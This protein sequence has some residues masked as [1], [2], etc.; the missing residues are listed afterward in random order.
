MTF[1]ILP[2]LVLKTIKELSN[3][4]YMKPVKHQDDTQTADSFRCN[5]HKYIDTYPSNKK[6][7]KRTLELLPTLSILPVILA[8]NRA[9]EKPPPM[10]YTDL[11]IYESPHANYKEDQE[12]VYKCKENKE[13]IVQKMLQ[14]YIKP[15]RRFIICIFG[16]V[17]EW[18]NYGKCQ[19]TTTL[20]GIK[21]STDKFISYMRDDKNFDLRKAVVAFGTATG[22]VFGSINC[23]LLR[24]FFFG[25]LAALFTGWLCFP[26]DTDKLIRNRAYSI[27]KIIEELINGFCG[28]DGQFKFERKR[29]P[30]LK[31]VC[32]PT[33]SDWKELPRCKRERLEREKQQKL[34]EEQLKKKTADDVGV[35]VQDKVDCNK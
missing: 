14:P 9:P 15:Y 13:K 5:F 12:N 34:L 26:K 28:T 8:I 7:T 2:Q 21:F 3:V 1:K 17:G 6:N 4:Y 35:C 16:E 22:F 30:C 23:Y 33:V 27:G 25:V 32:E 20:D 19:V 29:L 10:K 31:D 18:F 24:N 11:P